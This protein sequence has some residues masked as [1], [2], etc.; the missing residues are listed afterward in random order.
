MLRGFIIYVSVTA[1]SVP[2]AAVMTLAAG[3]LFGFTWGTVLVSFASTVGAT[4][5]FLVARYLLRGSVQA[6]VGHRLEAV[7]RGIRADGPSYLLTL[8]LI[9]L[10]PFV[11]VN[12]LMALTPIRL[13]DYY[14]YSQL[15]MLP[16]TMVF[17][18]AGT[19]LARIDN[20]ERCVVDAG[21]GVAGDSGSVSA[22]GQALGRVLRRRRFVRDYPPPAQVDRNII[23][24][25]AGSAGLVAALIAAAV[26]AKVTLI[27]QQRMGG[28]CLNTGCVPSKAL[29]KAARQVHQARSRGALR[30]SPHVA[31]E[32]DFAE[33]MAR[34]H[35]VVAQIAPHDSVERFESLGVECI[36]GKRTLVSPYRVAVNGAKCRRAP[37]FSPPAPNRWCRPSR[38]D[39]TRSAT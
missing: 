7:N 4:G 18:N 17:V 35:S 3:A 30:H 1:L 29:L 11:L 23:V 33:I 32:F 10:F 19:Q 37:L 13:R 28:D 9:P 36:Q 31:L 27:E 5:A 2:G 22:G 20:L 21:A 34:M 26:R 14:L 38:T 24:I 6:R 25:G 15:G 16:A 39:A 12:L 8:R